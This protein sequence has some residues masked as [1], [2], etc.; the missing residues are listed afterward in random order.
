[1]GTKN[2]DPDYAL[3]L[4]SAIAKKY[5]KDTIVNPASLWTIAK[6][7]KYL[8]DLKKFYRTS[9]SVVERVQHKG[10]LISKKL[11][12]KENVFTCSVCCKYAPKF[13]D[14]LCFLKYDCCYKCYSEYV[15]EREERWF[16]GWRPN[17]K[18]VKKCL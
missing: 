10:V 18:G 12:S 11:F 15:E 1:M 3:K 14:R 5:G 2:K 7:Q 17:L 13:Y 4:E 16:S 6:E 9:P 8:K